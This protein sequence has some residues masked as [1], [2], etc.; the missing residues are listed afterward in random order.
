M[1]D[2]ATDRSKGMGIVEYERPTLLLGLM[3]MKLRQSYM[4]E[5][6]DDIST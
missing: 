3:P 5:Q 1:Q 2:K 6:V 4:E